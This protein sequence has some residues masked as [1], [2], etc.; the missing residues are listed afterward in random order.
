MWSKDGEQGHSHGEGLSR[1]GGISPGGLRAL[2]QYGREAVRRLEVAEKH[3]LIYIFKSFLRLL[4]GRWI[5][6]G[7]E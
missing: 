2:F 4:C 7:S 6:G 1:T 5:V 3:A